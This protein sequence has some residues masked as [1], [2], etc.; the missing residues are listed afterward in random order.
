MRI[1][2][3]P[4]CG[5]SM[6]SENPD[7]LLAKHIEREH[8]SVEA[9]LTATLTKCNV[10]IQ[11]MLVGTKIPKASLRETANEVADLLKLPRL[12]EEVVQNANV[13]VAPVPETVPV[14]QGMVSPQNVS[15]T[16]NGDANQP[17]VQPPNAS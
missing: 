11:A 2:R 8:G 4:K 15:A 13:P 16:G 17:G 10:V 5:A 7:A 3:C 1:I 14:A 6:Q 9:K 12:P